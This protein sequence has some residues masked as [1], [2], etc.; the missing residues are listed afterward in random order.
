MSTETP[1][2][3]GRTVRVWTAGRPA[4]FAYAAGV[5]GILANSLLIAFFALQ[6]GQPEDGISLGSANDLVGS[7]AT[8]FM[9]P[10]ALAMGRRLPRRRA[11]RVAQAAGLTAM[12]LLTGGGP[13]LVLGVLAFEVATAIAVA[14][15]V[16]LGLWLFLVNHWF[17]LSGV[18]RP[19]LARFGEFLGAG[20]LAGYVIVG[21]GLLLP[22]MSWPQLV[23]FGVGLLIGLPAWLGIPVWF[24]AL[25][26]HLGSHARSGEVQAVENHPL[27]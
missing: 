27:P 14:G 25:G 7:L 19:R 12:A 9:I 15:Y 5:T 24:L 13:L 20:T 21:L 18:L 26:W 3:A 17:R 8:G 22:W 1:V 11:A 23:V 4:R 2:P 6:A 16:V 10:V